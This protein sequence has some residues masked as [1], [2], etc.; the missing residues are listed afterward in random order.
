[1]PLYDYKCNKCNRITEHL[2]DVSDR[3]QRSKSVCPGSPAGY[4]I[5]GL[6]HARKTVARRALQ[7]DRHR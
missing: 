4:L 7:P 2:K 3:P 5:I 1:M 6:G